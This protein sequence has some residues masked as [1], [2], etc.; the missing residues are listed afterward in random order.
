MS[1]SKLMVNMMQEGVM[2]EMVFHRGIRVPGL[3]AVLLFSA[4]AFASP[5][6]APESSSLQALSIAFKFDPGPTY[7]GAQWVSPPTFTSGLQSGKEA[8]VE[9]RVSGVD[10]SG[11]PVKVNPVWTATDPEMVVVTPTQG[12]Q[13][14]I[15]AKHA[16]ET[17]LKVSAQQ[18][19]TELLVKAKSMVGGKALQLEISGPGAKPSAAPA[20][21]PM[22]RQT[23][24]EGTGDTTTTENSPQQRQDAVSV[25]DHNSNFKT[26]QEKE[27]YALGMNTGRVLRGRSMSIDSDLFMQG[28]KDSIAGG[29]T[30]L[31]EAEVRTVLGELQL[32]QKRKESALRQALRTA[33]KSDIKILFKESPSTGAVDTR[34]SWVSPPSYT[35]AQAAVEAKAQGLDSAGE[36]TDITP[37]WT[38][39]DPEMVVV[40][41]VEGNA[42]KI[43]VKR[44][45]ETKVIVASSGVTK[46]L[47][48]KAKYV[49]E[50]SFQVEINQ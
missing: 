36:L 25:A 41:P 21:Y 7:G 47:T 3:A 39:A 8:S 4:M 26:S 29:Q 49:A 17:K 45:G 12:D 2:K 31:S 20:A 48:V 1:S 19:S 13:Y 10:K 16:G 18:V 27:S 40:S 15:T 33:R 44:P 37:T 32:A 14:R 24:S 35:A 11:R 22:I 28:L 38:P 6:A 50:N 9:A 30:L 46:E 23:E 34:E 43:S 42:V 5:Q